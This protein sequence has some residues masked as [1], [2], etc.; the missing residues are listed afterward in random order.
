M[1]VPTRQIRTT[2]R[3]PEEGGPRAAGS[4]LSGEDLGSVTEG[5]ACLG[6]L[7]E[8]T[9]IQFNPRAEKVKDKNNFSHI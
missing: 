6:A 4:R 2:W 1:A 7:Q 8:E 3:G 9:E 5:L